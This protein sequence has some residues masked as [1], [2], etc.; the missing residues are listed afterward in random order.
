MVI[1]GTQYY[2]PPFPER[3][4]WPQDMA[5]I[6][7]AGL[8]TVQLWACWGWIEP[9]PGQ[10]R[11]EDFDELMSL[12]EGAGLRVVVSTV[13]EIQPFWIHRKL[14]GAAMVDHMGRAVV[15]SVRGECNVGLTPGCCTDNAQL[16]DHMTAFLRTIGAR[17]AGSDTLIAWDCWNETRWA[18]QADG[19]VCYCPSTLAAFR[20]WLRARHGSLEGL[21]EAWRRRYVSWD[22]VVPG[23]APGRPYTDIVEFE[24][25]LTCGPPSTSGCG[26]ARCARPI[27]A[28]RCWLTAWGRRP[29][30]AARSMS[31]P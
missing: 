1:L 13:A 17:Y 5:A 9:A 6:A 14:P 8:D 3:R 21:S 11:F 10:Y 31:R 29:G 16:A 23:K 2:R 22:D 19:Y 7:E 24:A 12:A 18:V 4:Y 15:S 30:P 27:P 25:F 28:T 26:Q 20:E